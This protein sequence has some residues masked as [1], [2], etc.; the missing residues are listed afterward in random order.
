MLQAGAANDFLVIGTGSD[1]PG[2]D[3]INDKLPVALGNG[4]IQVR[5]TQGF[6][7][8]VLHHAWWKLKNDD[9]TESGELTAGGT[10]DSIIEGIKS[11]FD[12]VG[13]RSIVAIHLKD[14]SAFEP[15][16]SG[17]LQVQQSSEISGSVAVLHGSQFQ[18]FR[19]GAGVY[20]VGVLPWWTWLTLWFMEVPWL[21]AIIVFAMALLLAV[22]IR[23]WMRG[24]ARTRLNMIQE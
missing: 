9:R 19:I 24:K 22:W 23:Q 14:S 18:S 13:N 20:H 3:K 8:Q 10:P 16:I 7:I 6:F 11:P 12:L 4:K 1:Q 17:F 2:F 5:D 15:F 21:A